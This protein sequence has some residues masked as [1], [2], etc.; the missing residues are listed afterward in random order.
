MLSKSINILYL[1]KLRFF[2]LITLILIIVQ[3]DDVDTF[4]LP[5]VYVDFTINIET[6][7]QYYKLQNAGTGMVINAADVGKVSLG[8]N[9]NGIILYNLGDGFYAFDRTCPHDYPASVAVTTDGGATAVCPECN[10]VF[11][12]PSLGVPANGSLSK[13]PLVQYRASHNLNSG[14]IHVYN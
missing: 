9:N 8:Y 6:D 4:E 1:S 5:N 11:I 10:S 2:Y 14:S 13:Y 12:L 3:C 7:V